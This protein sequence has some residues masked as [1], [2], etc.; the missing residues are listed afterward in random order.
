MPSPSSAPYRSASNVGGI[1][2]ADPFAVKGAV[3]SL[4][5]GLVLIGW[6]IW[7]KK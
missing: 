3:V 6:G 1:S 5:L 2:W 4:A 7:R